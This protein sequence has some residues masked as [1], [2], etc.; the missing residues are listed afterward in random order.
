MF[1]FGRTKKKDPLRTILN[2]SN[3][4]YAAF[5]K[6]LFENMDTATK[7]HVLVA[8]QNLIPIISAMRNF[9]NERGSTFLLEDFIIECDAKQKSA[10]DEIN[11]RR[12]AW[13]MWAALA[14]RLVAMSGKEVSLRDILAEIWCDIARCAP[15]LKTLLPHNVVW[16]F[17]EKVWFELV[18]NEPEPEMVA[19]TINHGGPRT[20]WNSSAVKQLAD[21]F[22]LFYYESAGTMG[23]VSYFP[24][25]GAQK[26]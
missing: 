19:W 3:A 9:A 12:F 24:P 17:E 1:R 7:A 26:E 21:Q 8:Y 20:I 2:G 25:S 4:D 13:F 11:A 15:L 16:K 6:E 22:G 14:Y 10:N 18:I 5:V 23:P